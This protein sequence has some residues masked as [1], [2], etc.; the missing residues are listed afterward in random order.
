MRVAL[1]KRIP[2]LA[3]TV[4]DQTR[5]IKLYYFAIEFPNAIG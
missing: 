5:L 1:K 2:H 4:L 3:K